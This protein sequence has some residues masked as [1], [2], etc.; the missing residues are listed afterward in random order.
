MTLF[1][2]ALREH[3]LELDSINVF[4]V[5]DG[6]T[7][8]NL[9]ATYERVEGALAAG[10][11]D[12]NL[13]DLATT[14]ARAS[15]VGARGNSGVILSLALR[16]LCE[17][18]SAAETPDGLAFAAGLRRASDDAW[19]AVGRPVE[20]TILS[21]L[22]DAARAAGRAAEGG[23]G[24]ADVVD[25]ALDE[26]RSSLARTTDLLPELRAAG[27]V[28]AGAK[29]IVL[30][31]DA[32]RAAL[33]DRQL[34]EPVGPSGPVGRTRGP[35]VAPPDRAFEVQVL[36]EAPPR[37]IP[38]LRARLAEIGSSVVVVGAGGLFNVHVHTDEPARAADEV[39][40]A[41]RALET[42]VADLRVAVAA[43]AA[44]PA[45]EVRP[46]GE[47]CGLLVVTGGEG[48]ARAFASLGAR[49][50]GSAAAAPE[51][52]AVAAV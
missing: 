18:L 17:G 7:G 33:G 23:A 15:L 48:L 6:D 10:E 38:G 43:C 9:L 36:L 29:G 37:P 27:V 25:Q 22:R 51:P 47:A 11:G 3:R 24:L 19:G 42:H 5:A 28:D 32:L 46:A 45:R 26:A 2:R 44:A 40:K 50:I 13:D 49:V 20:G 31:L 8:T 12:G 52:S 16:G 14:I 34:S 35:S 1:G 21:V 39:A 41:G 30:L 4:P